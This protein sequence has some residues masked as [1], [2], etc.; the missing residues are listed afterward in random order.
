MRLSEEG[1]SQSDYIDCPGDTISYICAIASNTEDLHLIWSVTLLNIVSLEFI[2]GSD[3]LS[4]PGEHNALDMNITS[5]LLEYTDDYI[6]S[7]ITF[8]VLNGSMNGTVVECSIGD[9]GSEMVSVL[10]NTSG[11]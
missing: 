7:K 1:I 3:F 4:V 9:I 5:S 10:V 8:I 11:K 2:Y 6:K